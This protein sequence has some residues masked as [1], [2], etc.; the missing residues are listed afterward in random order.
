ML[1]KIS[2][3]YSNLDYKNLNLTP[4]SKENWSIAVNIIK[5]RITERFLN[6]IE[7]LLEV[8]KDNKPE[9]NTN[10]FT[11]L[12]ICCLLMETIQWF[13]EWIYNHK[14]KSQDLICNF[15][16]DIWLSKQD[17]KEFY[18]KIRCWILHKWEIEDY[19]LWSHWNI[20]DWIFTIYSDKEKV[21]DRTN[22]YNLI[23]N[24]FNQYL[25]E[26][27]DKEEFKNNFIK[28]MNQICHI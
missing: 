21:L 17:S 3:K 23:K 8:E 2:K 13:K 4:S 15:C 25:K 16:K 7:L 19:L 9:E 20:D 12:S 5:E 18:K 24:N 26:L 14:N 27:E 1:M 22:L 11:I 28:V 6:P 10:W